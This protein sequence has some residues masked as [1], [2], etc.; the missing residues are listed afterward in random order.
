MDMEMLL[1]QVEK[2]YFRV[3]GWFLMRSRDGSNQQ[4]TDGF[5]LDCWKCRFIYFRPSTTACN[6]THG[7]ISLPFSL[8]V[9]GYSRELAT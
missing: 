2:F 7:L 5:I 8:Q 6:E 4:S 3:F 1:R 9:L